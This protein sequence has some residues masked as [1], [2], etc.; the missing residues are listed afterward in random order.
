ML[1]DDIMTLLLRNPPMSRGDLAL[2]TGYS[3]RQ[4]RRVLAKMQ[5][6]ITQRDG[7]RIL[8]SAA[9]ASSSSAAAAAS[10]TTT[11]TGPAEQGHSPD[12]D[13]QH[14]HFPEKMS[15]MS[16]QNVHNGHEGGHFRKQIKKQDT[17]IAERTPNRHTQSPPGA[18]AVPGCADC[19]GEEAHK[20]RSCPR[21]LADLEHDTIQFVIV[22]QEF[23]DRLV[24]EATLKQWRRKTDRGLTWIYRKHLTLQVGGDVVVFYSDEPGD[25][26]GIVAWVRQN[27]AGIYRDIDSL[28]SRVKHPHE[29]TRDELTVI[30]RDPPTMEAMR[31]SLSMRMDKTGTFY[32]KSPNQNVPGFKAYYRDNTLR[33]EFDCRDDARKITALTMRRRLLQIIPVMAEAPGVFDE[34][35]T[36]YY[37]PYEHPILIDT[38]GDV[39]LKTLERITEQF[40][41][42]LRE[43]AAAARPPPVP[44][45]V[46]ETAPDP[47]AAIAGEMKDIDGFD[48]EKICWTIRKVLKLNERAVKVYLA[49]WSVWQGRG[50][51]GR[52]LKEDVASLLLRANE[53]LSA[54]D[55]ADAIER[56]KEVNLMMEDERLE[57]RF[58][59]MGSALARK[60]MAKREGMDR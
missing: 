1:G 30:I 32:L 3:E 22:D 2:A 36:D 40:T 47:L 27:F 15:T 39:F 25:L 37:N 56:L 53:P 23:R 48:I 26:S 5:G 35:L 18:P 16:T 13:V 21:S 33:C 8:Y 57:I 60:L 42:I 44:I 50:F 6:L 20:C 45:P 58:S 24:E 10:S 9:A 17:A 34:F 7:R 28:A 4:V 51:H 49:A 43:F 52:V 12:P 38:G 19:S 46:A 11:I 55:I 59:P 54:A 41:G 31:I 29:L 14:G